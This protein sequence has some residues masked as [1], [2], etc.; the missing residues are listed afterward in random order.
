MVIRPL[1][2]TYHHAR[3]AFGAFEKNVDCSLHHCTTN[4][5]IPKC[6]RLTFSTTFNR[7]AATSQPVLGIRVDVGV[8]DGNIQ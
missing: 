3:S 4:Q 5:Y 7:L 2:H 6:V 1:D 8:R